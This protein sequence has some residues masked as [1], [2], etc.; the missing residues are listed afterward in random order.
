MNQTIDDKSEYGDSTKDFSTN[1]N[2]RAKFDQTS[3][4]VFN[5]II[6]KLI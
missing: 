5:Y 1:N 6:I 3:R 4:G 2:V